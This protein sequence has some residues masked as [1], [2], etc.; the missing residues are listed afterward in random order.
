MAL[1]VTEKELVAVGAS[2]AAGCKPCTDYH[3]R[4]VRKVQASDGEIRKA[5]ADAVRIRREATAIMESHGLED[6]G[7][8]SETAGAG[9]SQETT[10]IEELVCVAA[11]FA[12]NCTAS[13]D[14]HLKAS[15]RV[16]IAEEE[17]GEVARLSAFIKKM[18]ASHVEKLA[19][20]AEPAERAQRPEGPSAGCPG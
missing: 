11:A 8:G 6:R 10:R 3:L 15:Q 14:R 19:G 17:L 2:I 1:T 13:L 12:V 18:A 16:G 5:I 7:A 20:V 9:S 4:E